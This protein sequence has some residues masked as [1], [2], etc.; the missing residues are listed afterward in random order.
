MLNLTVRGSHISLEMNSIPRKEISIL[1][2]C[3]SHLNL[4][5]S[6]S[7]PLSIAKESNPSIHR[8]QTPSHTVPHH[9]GGNTRLP[10]HLITR[11]RHITS[12]ATILLRS[13]SSL[14]RFASVHPPGASSWS[15]TPG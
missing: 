12:H 13:E 10:A 2:V 4:F 7:T 3:L 8:K 11:P 5:F 14:R 9:G 15:Y 1:S 6:F